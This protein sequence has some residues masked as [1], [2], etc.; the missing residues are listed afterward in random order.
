MMQQR[1]AAQQAA[2]MAAE[3]QNI[4]HQQ[5]MCDAC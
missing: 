4:A 5:V 1:D 2:R 3:N